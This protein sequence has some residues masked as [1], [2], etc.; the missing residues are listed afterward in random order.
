LAVEPIRIAHRTD[1]LN[2]FLREIRRRHRVADAGREPDR[3]RREDER[4]H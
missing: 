2:A 1:N 4:G 3:I